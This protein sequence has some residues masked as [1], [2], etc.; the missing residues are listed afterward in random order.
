M[1]ETRECSDFCPR[2]L[3]Q[4]LMWT[5]YG[6]SLKNTERL[7]KCANDCC[8][9]I[10]PHWEID[11]VWTALLNYDIKPKLVLIVYLY[12]FFKNCF[13]YNCWLEDTFNEV[14]CM[15]LFCIGFKKIYAPI[16]KLILSFFQHF[17]GF[18]PLHFHPS[19]NFLVYK[20]CISCICLYIVASLVCFITLEKCFLQIHM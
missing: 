5:F 19:C 3:G 16:C 17:Y 9:E 7:K 11:V 2:R 15:K 20:K 12:P 10:N 1:D 14:F 8:E 6:L 4:C 18:V 13:M